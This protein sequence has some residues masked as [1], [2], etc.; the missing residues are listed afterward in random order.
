MNNTGTDL[1]PAVVIR[2]ADGCISSAL[3]DG[4]VILHLASGKYFGLNAV[5]AR[6]WTLLDQ[7]K[8]ISDIQATIRAEYNVD[9]GR[10]DREVLAL[11]SDLKQAGLVEVENGMA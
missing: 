10:C 2:P 6:V 1:F 9:A 11:L 4:A 5:G 3:D 7:P 8:P